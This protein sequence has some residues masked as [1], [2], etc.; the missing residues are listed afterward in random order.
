MTIEFLLLFLL[1]ALIAEVLG[2]LGG[3]G[4]SLFFI[5]V[6]SYFL[7][8]H[9]VLG[10][11]GLFHVSSN[12]T[13]VGF[14]RK[15][16]DKNLLLYLGIPAVLLVL[17]GSWLSTKLQSNFLEFGLGVF[18]IISGVLMFVYRKKT[19]PR[20]KG[21][22]IVGG[23]LSGFF[24]GF[25]GTGGAI[26]GITLSMYDLSMGTFIATSAAIDLAVDMSRSAVY[27]SSGFVK[28]DIVYLIPLLF[29]VSIL[30]TWLGKRILDRVSI[31]QF[32]AMV[33]VLVILTGVF[34]CLE[35]IWNF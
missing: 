15:G 31:H 2:T 34:T 27:I 14:F 18:T 17:L 10:I 8:Y 26:R 30:G 16:I 28:W 1:L 7:E 12:L 5:P 32:K 33:T 11:T 22:T 3:F 9:E 6:A 20:N 23:V 25:F 4:S 19:I 35:I 13:K 24:A 29:F 21:I